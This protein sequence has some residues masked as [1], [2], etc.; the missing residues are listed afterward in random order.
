MKK[1]IGV[2]AV[3]ATITSFTISLPAQDK[4]LE[5]GS[6]VFALA[7]R[8]TELFPEA[9]LPHVLLGRAYMLEGQH[10]KAEKE[11]DKGLELDAR[12]LL[13]RL[14]LG[15]LHYSRG[16]WQRA[17]EEFALALKLSP[18]SYHALTRLGQLAAL[19]S[20]SEDAQRL[21]TQALEVKPDG[22]AA[23]LQLG[24]IYSLQPEN[25]QRAIATLKRAYLQN[26]ED[27]ELN[28]QLGALY[29]EAKMYSEAHYFL[30]KA[31]SLKPQNSAYRLAFA[32]CLYYEKKYDEALKELL[33]VSRDD[34]DNPEPHYYL[35]G[36]LLAQE[37]Y[38]RSVNFFRKAIRLRP[39]YKDAL[40]FIGKAEYKQGLHKRAYSDLLNYRIKHLRGAEV[41]PAALAESLELMLEIERILEIERLHGQEPD[42]ID[43]GQM[44]I[45]PGG[46]FRYGGYRGADKQIGPSVDVEVNTFII[47]KREVSNA[48]YRAFVLAT[49]WRVPKADEVLGVNRK[50]D[51][52]A[53]AKNFPEGMADLPVVNVSWEDAVAYAAWCGKRLPTEAE[54]ERAARGNRSGQRYPWGDR[55]PNE[56]QACYR[57]TEGPR[58][59]GDAEANDF[60]L[61]H[62]VG[63]AAEW[64]SDWFEPDLE[65]AVGEGVD[66]KG[67]PTGAKRAYR[68]GH[69]L[70]GS[71]D[72]QIAYRGGLSPDSR[73][74]YVSFRLAADYVA[75]EEND[76]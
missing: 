63:N 35:G 10:R 43:H 38:S 16:R 21:L 60:G 36:V 49:G 68:G 26:S 18:R 3:F 75:P 24:R 15:E 29:Y 27:A 32:K 41:D 73:S 2:V 53:A 31:V 54:W 64:C 72:I 70:G 44:A 51:W 37:K 57:S 67:P 14:W 11:L 34:R 48:E 52:N 61:L 56:R 76:K 5:Q 7:K 28:N 71:E 50:F 4:E 23:L 6:A 42:R 66:P 69:W 12:S 30:T 25:S 1:C 17:G 59:V 33:N 47:Q 20:R 19:E 46:K 62:I 40:F 45:I 65:K 55:A 22:Y 13:G 74:P 58:P 39:G 9:A 8:L